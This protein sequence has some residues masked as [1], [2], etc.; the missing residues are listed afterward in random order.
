MSAAKKRIRRDAREAAFARDGHRCRVCGD[1]GADAHHIT[2]R[3]EMPN[4]GYVAENLITLC[5]TCH[6]GAE[7][8]LAGRGRD[9][10]SDSAF[11][12][13]AL[14]ARI[15]STYDRAVMASRNLK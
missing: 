5:S 1:V 8:W 6:E 15:G 13:T 7:A 14:Y 4:G 3:E 2:P 11:R 9:D 12:P 10:M